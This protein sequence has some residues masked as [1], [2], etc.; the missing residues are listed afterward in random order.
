M[1]TGIEKEEY[2]RCTARETC[3]YEILYVKPVPSGQSLIQLE[4]RSGNAGAEV[5]FE[6]SCRT[7]RNCSDYMN[8]F[9]AM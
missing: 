4:D 2:V 6:L 1:L 3:L 8:W 9:I 5:T 7:V